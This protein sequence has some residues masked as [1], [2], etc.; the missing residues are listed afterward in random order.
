MG[1]W[2]GTAT[3][4][5]FATTSAQFACWSINTGLDN[6]QRETR[7]EK[8]L[9][10]STPWAIILGPPISLW[11]ITLGNYKGPMNI[12]VVGPVLWVTFFPQQTSCPAMNDPETQ[13][14]ESNALSPSEEHYNKEQDPQIREKVLHSMAIGLPF[15]QTF[16]LD[17]R[18]IPKRQQLI[19]ESHRRYDLFGLLKPHYRPCKP[20]SGWS[21]DQTIRWLE[22]NPLRNSGCI[23]FIRRT[24]NNDIWPEIEQ[25]D[26]ETVG[27]DVESVAPPS[28]PILEPQPRN[29]ATNPA[30]NSTTAILAV[31][32]QPQQVAMNVGQ[33]KSPPVTTDKDNNVG[34][35]H[36][37]G[38][39]VM[40]RVVG[41]PGCCLTK[42]SLWHQELGLI[43]T[44]DML[45]DECKRRLGARGIVFR[46]LLV[47]LLEDNPVQDGKENDRLLL[48]L[49]DFEKKF[50]D[51]LVPQQDDPRTE[52][53]QTSQREPNETED[54]LPIETKMPIASDGVR[55]DYVRWSFD[56]LLCS[57]S[58][59]PTTATAGGKHQETADRD[60]Q[61]KQT[62]DDAIGGECGPTNDVMMDATDAT[63]TD[64]TCSLGETPAMNNVHNDGHSGW[65]SVEHNQDEATRM[66]ESFSSDSSLSS[67]HSQF[68]TASQDGDL[69][70][71]FDMVQ[72]G[73]LTSSKEGVDSEDMSSTTSSFK[74]MS[75][76][77][78]E[79]SNNDGGT[80]GSL[81][82]YPSNPGSA[83]LS[84]GTLVSSQDGSLT[85]TSKNQ[86]RMRG[87]GPLPPVTEDGLSANA[88]MEGQEVAFGEDDLVDPID[89]S[90]AVHEDDACSMLSGPT[91]AVDG[92]RM[93]Q[94][95]E[96]CDKERR[97]G[98]YTG[99]VSGSGLVAP[100][101][102]HGKGKMVYDSGHVYHGGWKH[103]K[104]EDFG[105]LTF[106]EKDFYAGEFARGIFWGKGVR[107]WPDGSRYEGEWV[108]GKRSGN[109]SFHSCCGDETEGT[110]VEDKL[111]GHG[112]MSF[113]NGSRYEGMFVGGEKEGDCKY[114]DV[115]GKEHQG[116]WVSEKALGDGSS[117]CGLFA[118]GKPNGFGKRVYPYGDV[119]EGEY[120]NGI[121]HGRGCLTYKDGS[122]FEGVFS[123]GSDAVK[124]SYKDVYG[125][126]RADVKLSDHI[127]PDGSRYEGSWKD[128]GVNGFGKSRSENGDV[129]EGEFRDGVKHGRGHLTFV[130]G[131]QYFGMFVDGRPEGDCT[132][133]DA[134]GRKYVG[135]WACNKELPDGSRYDGQWKEGLA[136]GFGK[137]KYRYGATYEGEYCD[138]AKHEGGQL[139]LIDAVL[140]LSM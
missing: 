62:T 88:T 117:Y 113:A 119:Y 3:S 31:R 25:Q 60:F 69:V 22:K 42:G 8:I 24:L 83:E 54:N 45:L 19:D 87:A 126:E 72:S 139:M 30:M 89:R 56:D 66:S 33:L 74:N 95:T 86:L 14:N 100:A 75:L 107:Q 78:L 21:V 28:Q 43:P 92:I 4:V 110:W 137:R 59:V 82:T 36:L 12:S 116:V 44:D 134:A 32:P 64:G 125:R 136:H 81:G 5:L 10:R 111:E 50:Q 120:R 122:C 1:A 61:G 94:E 90:D 26:E 133:I 123:N 51:T 68:K 46:S 17:R 71:V 53:L 115:Y 109:G 55:Q 47:K 16:G 131:S 11:A 97:P 18:P 77:S 7:V 106:A 58:P 52:R 98:K 67:K 124:G 114:R 35:E 132:F 79:G 80:G 48:R 129:F 20:N 140:D 127:L 49:L 91:V 84:G 104:W 65:G 102:P 85:A 108:L 93:V 73:K 128:G 29:A 39:I 101:T 105:N 135:V 118:D 112:R 63:G 2:L 76:S 57:S 27:G 40:T 23:A 130:D 34:I 37:D 99:T 41:L 138:G 38:R 9:F 15:Y 103:G 6:Y 121:K 96:L 13:G 70:K